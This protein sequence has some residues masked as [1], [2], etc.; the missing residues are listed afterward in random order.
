[1]NPKGFP[2]V[3]YVDLNLFTSIIVKSNEY[4]FRIRFHPLTGAIESVTYVVEPEYEDQAGTWSE[5]NNEWKRGLTRMKAILDPISVLSE[6]FTDHKNPFI[7]LS[8]NDKQL[9]ELFRIEKVRRLSDVVFDSNVEIFAQRVGLHNMLGYRGDCSGRG[10][11]VPVFYHRY[12]TMSYCS[13]C[14]P[15][16]ES[17]E[18]SVG[19]SY[20]DL[21]YDA[22]MIPDSW[23][24]H[25]NK[26][27]NETIK[28][29]IMQEKYGIE[30]DYEEY[31]AMIGIGVSKGM[32]EMD[33]L[34][35]TIQEKYGI[36]FEK[37]IRRIGIE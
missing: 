8:L 29:Y 5:L 18:Y 37:S 28:S 4:I 23:S 31:L 30:F 21:L 36:E 15:D 12:Q 13:D 16:N 2:G 10:C 27:M 19:V 25:L 22:H 35:A 3:G 1:M 34:R 7:P 9:D 24:C 20:L 26:E 6:P 14:D 33:K 32:S 17:S 11:Q